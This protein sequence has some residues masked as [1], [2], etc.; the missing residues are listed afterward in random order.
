MTQTDNI[1]SMASFDW[2]Y[3]TEKLEISNKLQKLFLF[4]GHF[5]F[6][7]L[8]NSFFFIFNKKNNY[9][10]LIKLFSEK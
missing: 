9:T 8:K 1:E 2:G 5:F 7:F 6:D 4:N 10:D 3:S